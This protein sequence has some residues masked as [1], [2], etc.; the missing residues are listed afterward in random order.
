MGVTA[1]TCTIIAV[2]I[3][4]LGLLACAVGV[5]LFAP[6]KQRRADARVVLRVIA[7]L[8]GHIGGLIVV[9]AKINGAL[10]TSG[11]DVAPHKRRS[12]A[13]TT[14]SRPRSSSTQR[15]P[16]ATRRKPA[17]RRNEGE[18]GARS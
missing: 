2:V 6:D 10:F 11:K 18:A 9:A 17:K 3:V 14:R 12:R 8:F 1:V 13:R 5:A 15:R 4:I 7:K 16:A